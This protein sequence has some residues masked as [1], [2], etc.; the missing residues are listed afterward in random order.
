MEKTKQEYMT[1][2][3]GR[4]V[5]VSMIPEI[6]Q[7]RDQTVRGIMARSL[8]M[9]D[10]LKAFKSEI[11]SDI[12]EFCGISAE[13]HGIKWGG[14]KGNI[15][16]ATYDGKYK[17]VVAV[18]DNLSFNEKLQMAKTLID[19]CIRRWANDSR[20][21]IK[22]LV[23]DAFRVD[24]TGEINT[25]RILGLRRLAIKDGEWKEAM[26]AITESIMVTSSKTYM[27]FY[28]RQDDGSYKQIPL[29]VAA[30]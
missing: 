20:P 12:Q 7:L 10:S 11:W 18:N 2:P 8:A 27:R 23:D 22:V 6:D 4:Q 17:I 19:N 24:K 15:T 30:L 28:E 16:L 1:D 5:P 21:E 9:R 25:A 13:Q 29:D 26:Q 14:K 3:Q